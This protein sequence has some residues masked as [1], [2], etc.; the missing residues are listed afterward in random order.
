MSLERRQPYAAS[1]HDLVVSYGGHIALDTSSFTIPAGSVT[2]VIGPN[3]SGKS[4]LLNAIAGLL[5]P[6]SGKMDVPA[7]ASGLRRISYVL[8]TTKV[9]DALPI[10]VEEVVAMGRFRGA[11]GRLTSEDREAIAS[12]MERTDIAD[13]ARRHLQ[14][15]SGGQRQR[16]F[17]SQ[18]L[19]QNHDILLLDEPMTGIDLLTAKAIDDVIHNERDRGCT[20]I[21]TTHDLSE[22]GVADHVLLLAGR[23]V[24]FGTPGQVLTSENL[25]GAYGSALLHAEEGRALIDDAAHTPVSGRHSHRERVIYTELSQSDQHGDTHSR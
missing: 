1:A 3:G 4:T 15:L 14:E 2:A 7:R 8:Q 25:A 13:L 24:A 11:F 5:A 9:N 16:V 10:T 20:V 22:A 23:V 18:G 6:T 12:A 19:A 17:V 21:I